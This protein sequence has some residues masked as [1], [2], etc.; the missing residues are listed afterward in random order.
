[1]KNDL[2]WSYLLH[3][4][5]NMWADPEEKDGMKCHPIR[6]GTTWCATDYL[7]CEKDMWIKTTD[8]LAQAGCNTLIIDL[9][10]G[11]VYDSYP[12][13]AVKGSWT[14]KELGDEISRLKGLGFKVIPKINFSAIHNVWMGDYGRMVSTP[15]YYKFCDDIID[16]MCEL[17]D[18]PEYFHIGMD[19]EV[20]PIGKY[21]NHCIIRHGDLYWHDLYKLVNRVEKNGARAWMWADYFWHTDEKEKL[22]TERMSKDILCS[23]WYYGDFEEEDSKRAYNSYKKLDDLGFDQVLAGG[24]YRCEKNFDLTV[25]HAIDN[26]APKRLKGFMMTTWKPTM[27]EFSEQF[28]DSIKI[29]KEVTDKYNHVL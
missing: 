27:K 7:R 13:L 28:E 29:F 3:L 8:E 21:Q 26:I 19:E 5:Y 25:Q 2:M 15:Q 6:K 20:Y 18:N 22:F 4:G 10:E 12:E 11:V 24:N 14:K 23:N 17:F 16:E 1:M 9:A